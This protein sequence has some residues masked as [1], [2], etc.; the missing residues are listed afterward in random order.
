MAMSTPRTACNTPCPVWNDFVRPVSATPA[1]P[2]RV[3]VAMA[4]TMPQVPTTRSVPA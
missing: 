2:L 1:G 3:F 4:N